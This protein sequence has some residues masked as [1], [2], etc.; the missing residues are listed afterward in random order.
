MNLTL[1]AY[2]QWYWKTDLHNLLHFLSLRADSHAQYEIRVYADAMLKTVEAWVPMAFEAF[3]DY[4]MGAVTF[5]AQ[6]I[7]ILRRMLAGEAVTQETSG[8]SKREWR[9]MMDMLGREA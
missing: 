4:R 9:E 8:L 1:N 2:T 7:A 5:S 6:M 3:R